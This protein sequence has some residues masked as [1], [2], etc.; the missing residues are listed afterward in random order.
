MEDE[1]EVPKVPEVGNSIRVFSEQSI[2][3]EQIAPVKWAPKA[4]STEPA[5]DQ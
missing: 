1:S 4:H 2:N 5:N 3:Q